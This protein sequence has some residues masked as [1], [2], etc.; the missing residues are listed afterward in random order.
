[1]VHL[2]VNTKD[3]IIR[4][5]SSD[6]GKGIVIEKITWRDETH[7]DPNVVRIWLSK[8]ESEDLKKAIEAEEKT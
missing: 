7:S 6:D 4:L 1:M 8:E 5:F 2:I 3:R